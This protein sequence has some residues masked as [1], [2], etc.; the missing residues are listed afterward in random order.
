M[1]EGRAAYHQAHQAR[2]EAEAQRL[3]AQRKVL[4]GR[5]HAWV[6]LQLYQLTPA[7]YASMVRRALQQRRDAAGE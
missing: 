3:W 6:A 7:P 4:Q 2:A 1:S 5:W